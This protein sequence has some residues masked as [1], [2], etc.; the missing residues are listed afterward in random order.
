MLPAERTPSPSLVI[1]AKAGIHLAEG[2]G[3][4]REREASP[5]ALVPGRLACG[6]MDPGFR[7]GDEFEQAGGIA[8]WAGL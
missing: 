7:R 8:A 3:G 1:P 4:D 2:K 5:R 6:A